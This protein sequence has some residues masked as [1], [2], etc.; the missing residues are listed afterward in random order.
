[1]SHEICNADNIGGWVMECRFHPTRLW[2]FDFAGPF[3]I[4]DSIARADVSDEKGALT[5]ASK[6]EAQEYIDSNLL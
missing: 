4:Y 5:F 1:M 3:L 2:R 6:D